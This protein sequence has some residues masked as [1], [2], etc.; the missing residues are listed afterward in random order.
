VASTVPLTTVEFRTAQNF[1]G[2]VSR[3]LP[4]RTDGGPGGKSQVE[5]LCV[6]LD[7]WNPLQTCFPEPHESVVT[8]LV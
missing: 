1:P 7:H 5:A 8:I 6:E 3:S 4:G 2:A